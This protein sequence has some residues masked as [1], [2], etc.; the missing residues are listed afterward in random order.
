MKRKSLILLVALGW[1]TIGYA[2]SEKTICGQQDDRIPSFNPK[3]ARVL[4]IGAPA[5][6]TMTMIGRSCAISAGHCMATFEAA[7][8]NT[9]LSSNG[10]IQHPAKEDIYMVDKSS[11]VSKN[12]GVGNDYAVLRLK[13]NSITGNLPGDLQ[14]HYNVSFVL[15]KAG[16]MVRISG[17]GADRNDND[18]NFAQQTH[19][20]PI[21]NLTR[22]IMYHRAD[23]MGGSSGSSIIHENTGKII[24]IHT[25]GGCSSRGGAN[26][27]T[28]LATH[29][30]AKAAILKCLKWEKDNL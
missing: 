22:S 23:T 9:P 15:P 8:F 19:S 1:L 27:S 26:G 18:R 6:C 12:S 3:V 24:A 10:R 20:G 25:H 11:I 28:L 2:N 7:E 14:G 4:E 13:A 5:G 29:K 30:A 21:E 17:Y 16:D